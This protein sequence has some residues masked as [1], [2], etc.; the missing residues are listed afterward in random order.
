MKRLLFVYF[1]VFVS[2]QIFAQTPQRF[3][4]QSVV[5]DVSGT[6]MVNQSVSFRISIISGSMTGTVEYAETHTATTNAYGIVTLNVGGG[7]PVTGTFSSINWGSASHYIKVEADPTGGTTYLDMG[8]TQLLSVPYALYSENSGNI[9]DTVWSRSGNNIYNNNS[10]FV[11]IGTNNPLH[12][13]HIYNPAGASSAKIGNT[14]TNF[15]NRLFFGDGSYVYIGEE[16]ADDRLSL[17]AG[18]MSLN[19]TGG[20]GFG[21]AGQVLKSNGTTVSW[22]NESNT[23]Y[24]AGTGINI[25]GTT[26]TNTQP[27]QAVTLTQGGATTI[28]GTYPN[29]TI[30]STD[31]N[32]G[33]PG[34]LNKTVQFNN[35]GSFGGDTAMIWDNTNKRLGVGLTNPSGRVVIQGSAT[36]SL[37]EPLFEVKNSL[38]QTVFVVYPDSVHVYVKDG[39]AKSNKGGFAVSGR[40]NAKALTNNYLIVD[41]DRTNIYTGDPVLGFGITDLTSGTNTNYIH[42]TPNNSFIG[43]NS[44]LNITTGLYN[45]TFGY[46]AGK[47]MTSGSSN[48][49]IG[50]KSGFYTIS[51]IRNNFMGESAGYNNTTGNENDFIGFN[52]GR[53]NTT[54]SGNQFLGMYTGL[55]NT[56][57]SYNTFL[58]REAGFHNDTGDYNVFI[59]PDAGFSNVFG[60]NLTLVGHSADAYNNP[61]NSTAIGNNAT[62]SVSNKIRLG[63]ASVTVIEGQVAYTFPSDGRFKNNVTEE[64]KG[65]DFITKLRPVVYNFDTKKFDAFLMKNA[66]DSIRESK[67]RNTDYSNSSSVRQTGFIAQEVEQAAKESG[68]DFNGLHKP[69][70]D[71]DNYSVAYSLFVVPL[72]KSVQ[73]LNGKIIEQQSE[74]EKLKS[75]NEFYKSKIAEQDK[76]IEKIN[77]LLGNEAR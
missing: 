24:S 23:A 40:N 7:T 5:R 33:T 8:T 75:E 63:D 27:D 73:E 10:G 53:D 50:M 32:T 22:Q 36:A 59:G 20:G 11:G 39:G 44:G 76:K 31:L 61:V 65:L 62:V 13:L 41:P 54:G 68:Y 42:L 64:V 51:G 30:S 2:V 9:G 57:G 14:S 19:L 58:G 37:T 16:N 18:T 29:F 60:N 35:S 38:G 6:A 47:Y 12:Q 34:G 67:L 48:V 49:F 74:I 72:V 17:K 66:P 28:S 15:D 71:N 55:F 46:E 69:V 52:S 4:Y 43:Q 56:T 45:A 70:N 25:T 77:S 3:Q 21:T 1:A 26:I